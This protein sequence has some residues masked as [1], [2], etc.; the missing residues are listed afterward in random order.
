MGGDLILKG[1]K[2]KT[3]GKEP[4]LY[5]PVLDINGN[6]KEEGANYIVYTPLVT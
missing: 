2:S 3:R 1:G 4:T 5:T 6:D